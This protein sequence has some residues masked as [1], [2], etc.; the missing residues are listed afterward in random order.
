MSLEAEIEGYKKSIQQEQEQNEK[1][2]FVH[3]KAEADIATTKKLLQQVQE[4]HEALKNEYATYT[5]ML[6]ETEQALSRA[7]NVRKVAFIFYILSFFEVRRKFVSELNVPSIRAL[8]CHFVTWRQDRNRNLI[9]F[10]VSVCNES[11]K[12]GCGQGIMRVVV[13]LYRTRRCD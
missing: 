6:Q 3:N 2:T 11:K 13:V 10:R 5:R 1:L 8:N 4:K 12:I 9:K 7:N